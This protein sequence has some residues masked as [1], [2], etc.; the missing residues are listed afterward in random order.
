MMSFVTGAHTGGQVDSW[1]RSSNPSL[2]RTLLHVNPHEWHKSMCPCRTLQSKEE[3]DVVH[4][5]YTCKW[6]YIYNVG[7]K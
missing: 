3:I 6:L 7:I 5:T 1:S 2:L 4:A